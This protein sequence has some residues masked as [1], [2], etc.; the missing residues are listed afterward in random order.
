MRRPTAIWLA[1]AA[2]ALSVAAWVGAGGAAAWPGFLLRLLGGRH[3]SQPA[4]AAGRPQSG[5]RGSPSPAPAAR[6][7]PIPAPEAP[8]S[9]GTSDSDE[10]SPA[11][12]P[13]E[14]SALAPDPP[15]EAPSRNPRE[16]AIFDLLRASDGRPVPQ[17]VRDLAEE[18]AGNATNATDKAR[19]IYDWL[20]RNIVYDTR[21]WENIASGGASGY[22]HD[23]DPESVLERG[24]T[25]CIGY[26]WLFN[27]LCEAA[28]IEST[29]L[30]GDVRGYRATP[31]DE[32]VSNIRHAWNAV[33]LDDGQ[34]HL[35]DATW[36]ALQEGEEETPQSAAR[37]DYYYD[38]PSSQFIY[39]H[40]PENEDWQ[41]LD[42]AMPSDTAFAELPNL[43]PSFFQNGLELAGDY[44][45]ALLAPPGRATALAFTIPR[46]VRATATIGAADGS[47]EFTRIPVYRTREGNGG[48]VMPPLDSGDYVLRI[49]SGRRGSRLLD[50]SADFLI[51]VP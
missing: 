49:Y 51:K 41:L 19:A 43:K 37:A 4:L 25:V 42:E 27:N 38:T 15:H 35:L 16:P 11:P 40:L 26:A 23:H 9:G 24:S 3:G 50:C 12:P 10:F 1:M 5:G 34:W 6:A 31:D 32:L 7:A 22:I 36:G 48:A 2:I 8:G 45:S 47:T 33:K 13:G 21:E 17:C 18:I 14:V 20:T 30:I 46:G 29:W 28:G 39:D 44:T